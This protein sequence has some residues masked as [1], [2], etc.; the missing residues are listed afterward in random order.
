MQ[1]PFTRCT[2]YG[3]I[4]HLLQY[5]ELRTDNNPA[6]FV[7]LKKPHKRLTAHRIEHIIRELGKRAEIGKCHPH[8][9][10]ATTATRAIDHTL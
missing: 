9:F 7:G 1:H 4:Q 5:L 6:L 8:K 2:Y 3:G 10:R